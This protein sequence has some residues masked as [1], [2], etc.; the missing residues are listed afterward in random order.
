VAVQLAAAGINTLT[1]DLRGVG[2]SGGTPYDKLT[3]AQRHDQISNEG[4]PA[5]VTQPGNT[6]SR[7]LAW[8]ATSILSNPAACLGTFP[9]S[10]RRRAA[11]LHRLLCNI[12]ISSR[13]K[14]IRHRLDFLLAVRYFVCLQLQTKANSEQMVGNILRTKGYDEFVLVLSQPSGEYESLLDG[15]WRQPASRATTTPPSDSTSSNT[16]K[17]RLCGRSSSAERIEVLCLPSP[18]SVFHSRQ[19]SLHRGL[20]ATLALRVF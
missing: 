1:V 13:L 2:E 5:T 12:R 8:S 16:S 10:Y 11:P 6:W 4:I 20:D 18:S 17:R 15:L 19:G 9:V 3:H 7:S 14:N